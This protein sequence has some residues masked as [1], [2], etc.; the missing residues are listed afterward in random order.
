MTT[1]KGDRVVIYVIEGE[2]CFFTDPVGHLYP[3]LYTLWKHPDPTTWKSWHTWDPVYKKIIQ[4]ADLM[5]PGVIVPTDGLEPF[6]EAEMRCVQVRGRGGA[7]LA[8]GRTCLSSDDAEDM[9]GKGL[10]IFHCNGDH[11]W[12]SGSKETPPAIAEFN[13]SK[14][15]DNGESPRKDDDSNVAGNIDGEDDSRTAGP[16][17]TKPPAMDLDEADE[18]YRATFLWV[19]AGNMVTDATLPLSGSTLVSR[20]MSAFDKDLAV[21]IRQTSYRKIGKFLKAMEKRGYIRVKE[22]SGM[23]HITTVE[24]DHQDVADLGGT[25]LSTRAV[26]SS[27]DAETAAATGSDVSYEVV[28]IYSPHKAQWTVLGKDPASKELFEPR[29]VKEALVC[30]LESTANECHISAT[31]KTVIVLD[32]PMCDALKTPD[33]TCARDQLVSRFL[34]NMKPYHVIT[35]LVGKKPTGDPVKPKKGAVPKIVVSNA[36]RTGTKKITRVRG[37]HVWGIDYSEFASNIQKRTASGASIGSVDG[38]SAESEVIVQGNRGNEVLEQ[39]I[40]VFKVPSK[41]VDNQCKTGKKR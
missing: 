17:E 23:V 5:L 22:M 38:K 6:E 7:P 39:I 15:N 35:K 9:R 29:A 19:L 20:Y 12:E 4:G 30:Y 21:D 2:P 40:S 14:P 41:Y 34:A 1:A 32:G 13:L 10:T 26:A 16:S 3:T 27:T 31:E 8:V 33:A 25:G 18:T 11:L 24:W 37:L 36:N 28:E